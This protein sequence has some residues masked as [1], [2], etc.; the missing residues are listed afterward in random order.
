MKHYA[1]LTPAKI[2]ECYE[3]D[4]GTPVDIFSMAVPTTNP[5]REGL[6]KA[7]WARFRYWMIGSK[8]VD[9]FIQELSDRAFLIDRK[10]Q[11]LISVYS[12]NDIENPFKGRTETGNRNKITTPSGQES[13]KTTL[14]GSSSSTVTVT[15]EDSETGTENKTVTG[16]IKT[17]QSGSDKMT[18]TNENMPAISQASLS[19]YLSDRK[20]TTTEPGSSVTETPNTVETRTPDLLK[21][22]TETTTTSSNPGSTSETVRKA[23]ITET[24]ATENDLTVKIYDESMMVLLSKMRDA[25]FDPYFEYTNEFEDMFVNRW[26][27]C[28]CGCGDE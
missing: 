5:Y 22:S 3:N 27:T 16:S 15:K 25:Y 19:T 13:T 18:E 8:D 6:V 9:L 4:D 14:G 24:E 21:E 17:T 23:G 11:Y 26:N 1:G 7:M 20:I 10:Y 12:G 2:K 28:D